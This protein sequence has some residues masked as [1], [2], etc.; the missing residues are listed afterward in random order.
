MHKTWNC[1]PLGPQQ[2]TCHWKSIGWMVPYIIEIQTNRHTHIH[3]FLP[4]LERLDE[5]TSF[6]PIVEVNWDQ[7]QRAGVWLTWPEG[8]GASTFY[9][10]RCLFV[11]IVVV[12]CQDRHPVTGW[13]EGWT[14]GVRETVE[15]ERGW[16]GHQW[17][18]LICTEI[19]KRRSHALNQLNERDR[20]PKG[21][22]R[23]REE[24]VCV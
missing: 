7:Q 13:Q 4:L 19:N 23:N 11:L 10:P 2:H 6:Y 9:G 24:D 16:N 21:W 8:A 1:T 20:K 14:E 17:F 5:V 22:E 12:W 3:R 15:G 18:T